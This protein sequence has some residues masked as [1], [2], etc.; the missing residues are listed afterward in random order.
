VIPEIR[1]GRLGIGHPH[2][3]FGCFGPEGS[4]RCVR[5][6][7]CVG[8]SSPNGGPGGFRAPLSAPSVAVPAR[9]R[10]WPAAATGS[11]PVFQ[12]SFAGIS[13]QQRVAGLFHLDPLRCCVQYR[14]GNPGAN[15]PPELAR[16]SHGISRRSSARPPSIPGGR[17]SS[18]KWF[19]FGRQLPGPPA[20]ILAPVRVLQAVVPDVGGPCRALWKGLGGRQVTA[21][22]EL[23]GRHR[24]GMGRPAGLF[25]AS[26]G[27]VR[28]ICSA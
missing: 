7:G 19:F 9:E 3:E 12:G 22:S 27:A 28:P 14:F 1:I 26:G 18:G 4:G 8:N 5:P 21:G 2:T 24:A 25:R 17:P 23:A 6:P 16:G 13:E 15:R 11:L 10:G 20:S